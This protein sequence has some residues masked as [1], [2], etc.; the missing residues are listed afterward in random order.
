[1]IF[2]K[3]NQQLEILLGDLRQLKKKLL[4]IFKKLEIV[5]SLMFLNQL[6]NQLKEKVY[7]LWTHHL[8]LQNV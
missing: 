7:I 5:N 8:L 2:L 3:V 6:K 4:V 1:M